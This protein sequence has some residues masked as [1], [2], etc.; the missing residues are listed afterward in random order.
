MPEL[1]PEWGKGM[2]AKRRHWKEKGGRFWARIA[3][4]AQL[5][6]HFGN[7]TELIEPLGGDLRLADRNHAAAVARLQGRLDEARQVLLGGSFEVE[8]L[9]KAQT[10]T[11]A[12][13]ERAAWSHYIAALAAN[14]LRRASLPTAAEIDAEY[15]KTMQRIEAGQSNPDRSHSSRFNIHA[16]Y[17]LKAGARYFDKNLRTRRLAALRAAIPTGESRLVD[18]AVQSY[19]LE[20]NLAIQPG[21]VDWHQ[22]AHAFTRAEIEALQRSI[23][24][25]E[26][27]MGG[28]PT[29][30]LIQPPVAPQ[31][32]TTPI[33]LRKLFQDYIA[34][35]QALG[36]HQDGGANWD[37][38]IEALIKFLGHSDARRITRLS[39]MGWRDSL[40]ASGLS[41]KTVADKHLAA[42]RAVLTWAFDNA[43]LPTNEAEKVKQDLP[44]VVRSREAGYTD[45]EATLILI[46]SRNYEPAWAPNPSNRESAHITA[47]KRWVPLLCAF[48]GARVTEV[49][50][51]R[52][53]DVR[54]EDGRWIVRL[55]PGAGSVKSGHYR[56]VPLHRQVVKLGF[57]EFVNTSKSGPMFHGAKTPEKYLGSRLIDRQ[58]QKMTV[59]ARATADRKTLGHLS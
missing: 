53:E 22:L 24:F 55:T 4:P 47:A 1:V 6:S 43:R 27:N 13:R 42:I 50:Q 26:G 28:K 29:D 52:K 38:S 7:K 34:S 39:L 54:Q 23:E 44:K 10:I 46:A 15:E 14:E 21:S 36:Y 8:E 49:T 12:D 33:P 32:K 57:I 11:D 56:D 31:E 19:V 18:A 41:A 2:A 45:K 59:A 51:L 40:L 37:R 5:R 48:T 17:E 35:R 3:I 30:P 25:D 9:R 58:S 20:H 16:D